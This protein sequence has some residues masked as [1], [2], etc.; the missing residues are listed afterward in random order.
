MINC[1]LAG[2]ENS[3]GQSAVYVDPNS[4]EA[5]RAGTINNDY[6][7]FK[8]LMQAKFKKFADN[9]SLGSRIIETKEF[10]NDETKEVKT[11]VEFGEYKWI[12]YRYLNFDIYIS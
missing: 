7:D 5:D 4:T 12:T 1:F 10:I 6:L 8:T 9:Y 11:K 3:V 2:T